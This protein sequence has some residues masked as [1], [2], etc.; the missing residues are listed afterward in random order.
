MKAQMDQI[1]GDP[2]CVHGNCTANSLLLSSQQ[3]ASD[4]TQ[5]SLRGF[6]AISGRYPVAAT[7]W[8]LST[9]GKQRRQL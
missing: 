9:R 5:D 4:R 8:L 7:E 3:A 1:Q 6:T 2:V